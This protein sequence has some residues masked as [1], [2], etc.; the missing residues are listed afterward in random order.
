MWRYEQVTGRLFY[1]DT[2][3]ATGYSGHSAGMNNPLYQNVEKVGPLP[4]GSYLIGVPRDTVKHGKFV[5]PLIPQT[6]SV[7]FGRSGFLIHGDNIHLDHTASE[8][9]IIVP[10]DVRQKIYDSGVHLLVVVSGVAAM[11]GVA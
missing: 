4:E 3:V 7:T 6:G 2:L 8:G 11:Q 10:R 1:R 5:L 9:C